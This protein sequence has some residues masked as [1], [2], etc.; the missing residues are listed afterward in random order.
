[1]SAVRGNLTSSSP[2][3][4]GLHALDVGCGGGEC[5][6]TLPFEQSSLMSTVGMRSALAITC[7]IA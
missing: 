4:T 1:M 3:L 2:G 6:L 7:R 5:K